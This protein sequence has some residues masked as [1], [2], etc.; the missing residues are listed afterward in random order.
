MDTLKYLFIKI[1]N[2]PCRTGTGGQENK[3]TGKVISTHDTSESA[4]MAAMAEGYD[5]DGFT[6]LLGD[7]HIAP[8][9]IVSFGSCALMPA[10]R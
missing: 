4:C 7:G 5:A 9:D 8:G 10:G 1:V 2:K 6:V 3:G